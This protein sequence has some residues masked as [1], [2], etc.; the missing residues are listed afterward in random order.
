M[1]AQIDAYTKQA[2]QQENQIHALESANN[3]LKDELNSVQTDNTFLIT[4]AK[5]DKRIIK[6][7]E[8]RIYELNEERR[9]D[10]EEVRDKESFAFFVKIRKIILDTK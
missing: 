10:N 1:Q 3:L 2:S 4:M 7:L 9:T 6:E 5:E 8:E